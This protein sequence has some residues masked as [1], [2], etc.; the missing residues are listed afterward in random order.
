[1]N[2]D[3]ASKNSKIILDIKNYDESKLL[4][5][6]NQFSKDFV[7]KANGFLINQKKINSFLRYYKETPFNLKSFK[8]DLSKGVQL[9]KIKLFHLKQKGL[10][11][12]NAFQLVSLP[13]PFFLKIFFPK[14]LFLKNIRKK[15]LIGY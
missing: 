12:P 14:S 15:E 5:Y 4:D 3:L 7:F 13:N 1:M 2:I 6:E 11:L 8:V 10:M 9:K